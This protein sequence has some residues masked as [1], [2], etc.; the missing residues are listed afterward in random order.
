LKEFVTEKQRPV[1]LD[2]AMSEFPPAGNVA[3]LAD[4]IW[5]AAGSSSPPGH[6]RRKH[7]HAK[8]S[9]TAPAHAG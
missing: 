2:A 8:S 4:S 1:N 5:Y 7:H 3:S 6:A 9:D